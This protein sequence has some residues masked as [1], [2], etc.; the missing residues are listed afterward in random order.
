MPLPPVEVP[1]PFS[2]RGEGRGMVIGSLGLQ[3]M[4]AGLGMG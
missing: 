3:L 4:L 1:R 2:S